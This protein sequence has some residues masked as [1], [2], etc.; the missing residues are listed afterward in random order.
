MWA[1]LAGDEPMD[2]VGERILVATRQYARRQLTWLRGEPEM[3]YF[4]FAAGNLV[5][6]VMRRLDEWLDLTLIKK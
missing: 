3:N 5:G 1:A 6:R 2:K 4:E